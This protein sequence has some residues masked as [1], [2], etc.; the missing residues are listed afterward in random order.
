M[1]KNVLLGGVSLALFAAALIF[2]ANSGAKN[3]VATE[4]IANPVER[5]AACQR[6]IQEGSCGCTANNGSCSCGR[7][8]G[9]GC[10]ANK[11]VNTDKASCGCQKA[12]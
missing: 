6:L 11:V 1:K 4:S 12:Q 5:P 2:F 7:D 3:V 10:S 8:G 9:T